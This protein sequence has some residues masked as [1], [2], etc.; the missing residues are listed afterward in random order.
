MLVGTSIVGTNIKAAL[1][2]R[3]SGYGK[4]AA[5]CVNKHSHFFPRFTRS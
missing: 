3:L 4:L 1:T 5:P 2:D